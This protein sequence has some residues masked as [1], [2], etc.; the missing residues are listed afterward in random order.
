MFSKNC[1]LCRLEH[2][3][4]AASLELVSTCSLN[5]TSFTSLVSPLSGSGNLREAFALAG[6]WV[7]CGNS[8]QLCVCLSRD[9]SEFSIDENSRLAESV[10]ISIRD[11]E[12]AAPS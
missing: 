2:V 11:L 9:G 10:G 6:T 8:L 4:A 5:F 7:T 1:E 12:V 3:Y